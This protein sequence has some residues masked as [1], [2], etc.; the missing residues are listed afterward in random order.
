VGWIWYFLVWLFP[1]LTLRVVLNDLRQF[2]EH[3]HGRLLVYN[4]HALERFFFGPFNFHLHAYHHAY[5]Q[6]PWFVLPTLGEAA[7]RKCPDILDYRTY[8]GELADYVAGRDRQGSA[9]ELAT[10]PRGDPAGLPA[11]GA[12]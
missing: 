1:V 10:A 12:D 2:L 7:R 11:A 6:E 5:P 4:T 9:V 3:R 8:L